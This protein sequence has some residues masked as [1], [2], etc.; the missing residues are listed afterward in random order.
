MHRMT[1]RRSARHRFRDAVATVATAA[2]VGGIVSCA[3]GP[4]PPRFEATPD[5]ATLASALADEPAGEIYTAALF[6]EFEGGFLEEDRLKINGEI[7]F[8]W[9]DRVRVIGAYGAFRKVFDLLVVDGRFQL[10]DNQEGV[11]YRGAAADDVAARE[12]GFAIRPA[13]IA[14]LLRIDGTGPL[15]EAEI[16]SIDT[17]AEALLVTFA[18]PGDGARWEARFDAASL[19]LLLARRMDEG[20]G[21]LEATY[22]GYFPTGGRRVPRRVE[23]RRLDGDER[24]RIEVRSIR[25]RDEIDADVFDESRPE[26]VEIVDL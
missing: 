2:I 18:V 20:G 3:G 13:D 4:R 22:D 19:D 12:L 26:G 7:A 14:R 15:E 1:T 8:D 24:V 5:P 6:L 25:F 17:G 23:V 16:T 11:L 9:P 10:F 21:G